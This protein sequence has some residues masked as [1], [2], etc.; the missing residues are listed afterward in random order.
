MAKSGAADFAA[1]SDFLRKNC[2]GFIFKRNYG[3][4]TLWTLNQV[5]VTKPMEQF[6]YL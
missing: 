5:R 4:G 1:S 2:R 3:T 6:V